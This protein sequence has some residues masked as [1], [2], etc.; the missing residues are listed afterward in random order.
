MKESPV[1]VKLFDFVAWVIPLTVKFPREQRFVVAA[2][3]QRVTLAAHEALIRAGHGG[4]PAVTL[5]HLDEVAVQ[6]AL[7]RF[8]LRLS[9]TLALITVNQYEYAAERLSEIGRLVEAWR[10]GCRAKVAAAVTSSAAPGVP[11]A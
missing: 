5:A 8:Y 4:A 11:P 10:R 2:A 1:F 9:H 7:V 3:L 6:L